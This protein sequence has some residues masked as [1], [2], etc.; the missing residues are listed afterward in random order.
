MS[1]YTHAIILHCPECGEAYIRNEGKECSCGEDE[2]EEDMIEGWYYLHTNGELIYKRE[3]GGTAADIRESDFAKGLWPMDPSDREGAWNICVEGLAAGANLS[4]VKE[5]AAK[6]GCNDD[7][8]RIYA[9][10]I[11]CV[12]GEDGS[13][14]TATRKDFE[15]LQVSPVGFGDTYLEAMAALCKELGF[16]PSKMWGNKFSDLLK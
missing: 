16:R 8:A 14:K 5:L 3:L 6:W 15:N 13:Q 1:D 4:R 2:K 11:G 10:Y 9:E 7:D 12:L